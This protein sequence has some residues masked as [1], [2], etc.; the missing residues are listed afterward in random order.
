MT[1]LAK[2]YFR[3]GVDNMILSSDAIQERLARGEIF[4]P[5][6]WDPSC[7]KEASYVLRIDND[8][9]LVDGTFYDPGVP[10]KGSDFVVEPGKIAILSTKE[11]LDMPPGPSRQ[12]SGYDLNM[13]S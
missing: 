11:L 4:R 13:R 2:T 10:Y 12:R 8:G 9:L 6:T 5:D 7:I 3:Q 1:N